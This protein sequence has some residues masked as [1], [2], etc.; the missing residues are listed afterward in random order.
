MTLSIAIA[1]YNGER[2][3]RQQ[4]DSLYSQTRLPDEV[5]VSDDGSTDGTQV[6]LQEYADRYGLRWSVNDGEHGVNANFFR[7]ISLCQG[8]YI[9]ICDQDD[10]W[11]ANKLER[12]VTEMQR[13]ERQHPGQPLVVCSE[14]SHIDAEGQVMLQGRTIAAS[15]RWQDTLMTTDHGQ[16]CTMLCNRRLCELALATYRQ[17]PEA[18]TVCYDVLLGFTAAILGVKLNIGEPLMYYRHHGRNVV[19]KYGPVAHKQFRQR[20]H[21]MQTYYPFLQDYRFEELR[22]VYG[23]YRDASMPSDIRTYLQRASAVADASN[24]F[25]GLPTI[26]RMPELSLWMKCRLWLL[27][28]V[29]RTLKGVMGTTMPV[30]PGNPANPETTKPAL[31]WL[32]TPDEAVTGGQRWNQSFRQQ[33]ES[34]S[35]RTFTCL[36]QMPGH[37]PGWRMLLAPLAELVNL[38]RWHKGDIVFYSDTAY[39]YHTLLAM[40]DRRSHKVCIIHHFDWLGRTGLV[41]RIRAC[42]MRLYYSMM[43]EII[44]P[45]PFTRDL[46]QRFYP[47]TSISYIPLAFSH[48]YH[49]Y[50]Y[51]AGRLLYVGTIE[52]RKGLHLL[53]ESLDILHRQGQSFHA[54]LVGRVVDAA[55]QQQLVRRIA[56]LG[57]QDQITWQ[58]NIPYEELLKQYER[59]EVFVFPSQLEG[60]GMVLVEAMQHGLP[61]VAYDN[62]AM[63]YSITDGVNGYLAANR[64]SRAFA[65]RISRV[66]HNKNER[67]RIQAGIRQHIQSLKTEADFVQGVKDLV[68]KLN[69]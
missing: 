31:F 49:T 22:V 60:Y 34:L 59:A 68:N 24:I 32:D 61:I 10:I 42:I 65:E 55:Y 64:D 26:S 23:L 43:D 35:G 40:L 7:A 1:T 19:D 56:T 36:P 62:S 67:A 50:D 29:A 12:H 16:G 3:L 46:A 6:I 11:Y 2:F 14:M 41:W 54:H 51:Q 57:L 53:L 27:T 15:S 69:I 20:V 21:D 38:R 47:K 63:P 28:P 52:P 4:L 25:M 30:I 45:S 66:L 48:T 58:D 33:V 44:V 18:D 13:L 5:V 39:M 9:Q 37:Y 17:Q 8:D